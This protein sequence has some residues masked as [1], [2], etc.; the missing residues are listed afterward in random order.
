MT[1]EKKKEEFFCSILE[2]FSSLDYMLMC[3][4]CGYIDEMRETDENLY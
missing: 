2:S 4:L 1:I 3:F